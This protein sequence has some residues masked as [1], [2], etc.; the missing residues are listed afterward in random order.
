MDLH[1]V[2]AFEEHTIRSTQVANHILHRI[3]K[4]HFANHAL[5]ARFQH[6]DAALRVYVQAKTASGAFRAKNCGRFQ[7][8]L[9]IVA[10]QRQSRWSRLGNVAARV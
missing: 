2:F 7:V 1:F 4:Q 8:E 9:L 5:L 6:P 10:G 3:A